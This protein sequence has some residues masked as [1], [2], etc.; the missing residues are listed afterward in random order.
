MGLLTRDSSNSYQGSLGRSP[1]V[2]QEQF[3]HTLMEEFYEHRGDSPAKFDEKSKGLLTSN[4]YDRPK[5]MSQSRSE[6]N[7]QKRSPPPRIETR[8]DPV[9]F[10]KRNCHITIEQENNSLRDS[11]SRGRLAFRTPSPAKL[12]DIVENQAMDFPPSP[13][14]RSRSP[15]KQL[16]GERGWLGR[17]TS[18]KELPSEEYRKTGFKHWGEKLKQKVGEIVGSNPS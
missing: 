10:E 18:M 9:L 2:N 11:P 8:F 14:K 17:S 5:G 13:V 7:L 16:F 1:F 6:G 15:V 4:S 12:D 3:T